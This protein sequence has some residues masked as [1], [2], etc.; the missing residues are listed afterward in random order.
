MALVAAIYVV[1]RFVRTPVEIL[2][3]PKERRVKPTR[4]QPEHKRVWASPT[5]RPKQ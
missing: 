3:L 1:E 5:T 4:P 2:P